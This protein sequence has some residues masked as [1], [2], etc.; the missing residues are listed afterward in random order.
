[1]EPVKQL[2]EV[3]VLHPVIE[4]TSLGFTKFVFVFP[5]SVSEEDILNR[6]KTGIFKKKWEKWFF[7][8]KVVFWTPPKVVSGFRGQ[9]S[10]GLWT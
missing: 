5:K 7:F 4:K 8:G 9:G 3:F 10:V 6:L 2:G 1:M